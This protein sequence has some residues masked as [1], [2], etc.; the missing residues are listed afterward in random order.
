MQ[1]ELE[2]GGPGKL[3]V[4]A[5]AS[6]PGIVGARDPPGDAVYQDLL[7]LGPSAGFAYLLAT[8]LQQSVSLV[9]KLD[10]LVSVGPMTSVNI[11]SS[12]SA[13]R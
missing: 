5:K 6:V 7:D 10:L 3:Q 1:E 4:F 8:L 9:V 2:D 13:G 11:A 12:W